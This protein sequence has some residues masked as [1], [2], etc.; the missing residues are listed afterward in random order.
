VNKLIATFVAVLGAAVFAGPATAA[1]VTLVGQA[2]N[3]GTHVKL[4]AGPTAA[5]FGRVDISDVGIKLNQL[6]TLSAEFNAT[7]DGCA[8]GSP[9]YT[10]LLEDGTAVHVALGTLTG[11]AFTCATNSSWE[12]SGNLVGQLEACRWHSTGT[13]SDP[14]LTAPELAALSGKT[15]T[16][17]MLVAD[18][19]WL[20]SPAFAD[21]E[22]TV[23]VRN[24]TINDETFVVPQQPPTTRVNPAKFCK[25]ERTRLG[26][27]AF[28]ELWG[29]N[30]NDRNAFGKC[31]SATARA[32]NPSAARQHKQIMNA[33]KAC[34][35]RGLKGGALGAC[36]AARDG[37]A[38][39]KTEAQER[40][41][42]KGKR[43]GR[44]G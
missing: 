8:A 5:D 36:V 40:K 1:T 6:T 24:L 29:T 9:R 43:K 20:G 25:A 23:L 13:V 2:T 10:L 41:K 11:G 44:K 7:D 35:A 16:R 42:G 33:A 22:Q 27:A 28:N 18:A 12:S 14:C 26:T 39:T 3:E 4:V 34:K 37:V 19:S 21:N 15:I 17:V 30:A 32:Q 38:A 31:V